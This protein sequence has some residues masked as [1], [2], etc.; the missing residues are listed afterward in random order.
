MGLSNPSISLVNLGNSMN[1][2]C[3]VIELMEFTQGEARVPL[4]QGFTLPKN[5]ARHTGMP[6]YGEHVRTF[7]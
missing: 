6:P 3:M 5:I 7:F 1:E 2:N 4:H